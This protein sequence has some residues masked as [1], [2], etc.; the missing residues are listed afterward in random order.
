MTHSF[1]TRRSSDLRR[2]ERTFTDRAK[3]QDVREGKNPTFH[4]K[5]PATTVQI[6]RAVVLQFNTH[7]Y[8]GLIAI[9]HAP[10]GLRVNPVR[11]DN[12]R[13]RVP[14]SRDRKSTRLN[15]SH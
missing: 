6:P 4:T 15:S 13:F 5:I 10:Q 1:P 2:R 7:A 14:R 8:G 11:A 9:A 12:S 3:K